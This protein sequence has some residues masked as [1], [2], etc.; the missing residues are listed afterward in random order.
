[1]VADHGLGA[2]EATGGILDDR[3]GLW[4]EGVKGF[5][6]GVAGLE[7]G[8]LSPKRLIGQLLI[9][10]LIGVDPLDQGSALAEEPPM[11]AAGEELE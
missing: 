8:G 9:L 10:G 4:K 3:E 11:V 5:P 1:V 7:L 2:A 6:F